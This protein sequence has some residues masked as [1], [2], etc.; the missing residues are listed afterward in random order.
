MHDT[1]I[2]AC[3]CELYLSFFYFSYTHLAIHLINH[4]YLFFFLQNITKSHQPLFAA[5]NH[6]VKISS[7][8]YSQSILRIALALENINI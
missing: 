2:N 8:R 7:K 3:I 6:V 4:I 5:R 1:K